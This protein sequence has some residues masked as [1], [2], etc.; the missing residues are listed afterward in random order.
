MSRSIHT[1]RKDVKGLTN[2]EV[3]EQLIDPSSD[4]RTLAKKSLLKE[5]VKKERKNKKSSK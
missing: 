4:L 1:T 2:K 3:A 5:S